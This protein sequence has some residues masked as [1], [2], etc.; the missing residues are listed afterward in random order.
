M[1]RARAASFT[2]PVSKECYWFELAIADV[3]GVILRKSGLSLCDRLA[4]ACCSTR[5]LDE[6]EAAD[7][8]EAHQMATR[9]D[10]ML[11]RAGRNKFRNDFVRAVLGRWS[12]SLRRCVAAGATSKINLESIARILITAGQAT[13]FKDNFWA[14]LPETS[15]AYLKDHYD[16]GSWIVQATESGNLELLRFVVATFSQTTGPLLASR[17]AWTAAAH[18]HT[19][20]LEAAAAQGQRFSNSD[21]IDQAC[22]HGHVDT[23]KYLITEHGLKASSF[24][25]T[26]YADCAGDHHLQCIAVLESAGQRPD[27]ARI[28]QTAFV[29][30]HEAC[31]KHVLRI[32]SVLPDLIDAACNNNNAGALAMIADASV[33]GRDAVMSPST[34]INAIA[35]RSARCTRFLS[36]NNIRLARDDQWRLL[37]ELVS[38]LKSTSADDVFA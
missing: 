2:W 38:Y 37:G 27:Y 14:L 36:E 9:V 24:A 25:A 26:C 5:T 35:H 12:P 23:T 4:F 13:F 3:R 15:R 28:A 29:A 6:A 10:K 11:G 19:H 22:R 32:P 30:G 1:K 16:T 31:F 20:L 33:D 17:C 21:F 7:T 18:G 34:L 8:V